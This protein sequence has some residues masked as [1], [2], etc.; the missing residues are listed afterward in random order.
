M[1]DAIGARSAIPWQAGS[2]LDFTRLPGIDH[3]GVAGTVLPRGRPPVIALLLAI[4]SPQVA[5]GL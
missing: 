1:D 4:L 3:Q 5:E 2:G